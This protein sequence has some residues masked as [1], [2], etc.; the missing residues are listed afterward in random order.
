MN[1]Y[2]EKLQQSLS[3][4]VLFP[5]K[6]QIRFAS[7]LEHCPRCGCSVRVWKTHTREVATLPIGSFTAH[8]TQ[9]YCSDCKD[10]GIFLSTELQQL[11]PAGARYGYDVIVTIGKALFLHCRN[12]QQIQ[13]ELKAKNIQISLR[14][15][16]YLGRR[17]IVYLTLVH[18]QSQ[19][20]MKQFMGNL[21][22]V[23]YR[24]GIRR[25][26]IGPPE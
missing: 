14:E 10:Q 23:A 12:S 20:K 9:T 2:L 24:E 18:E 13:Q 1:Y 25:S 19:G 17:F 3:P 5:H 16:D 21:A 26:R 4:A 15:I 6:S 8:E 7:D 22:M 11:I